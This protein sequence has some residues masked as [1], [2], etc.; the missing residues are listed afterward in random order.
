MDISE[1][2]RS[3][4]IKVEP[5]WGRE[6]NMDRN[7][8]NEGYRRRSP[9]KQQLH[10]SSLL[11]KFIAR[12]THPQLYTHLPHAIIPRSTPSTPR[13][14]I[15]SS[16]PS[17]FTTSYHPRCIHLPKLLI[18]SFTPPCFQTQSIGSLPI[19]IPKA[20]WLAYHDAI[21]FFPN[22]LLELLIPN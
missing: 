14:L 13:L 18:P 10:S 2:Y 4:P 22:S 3:P 20:A 8:M 7:P 17:P 19:F 11:P 1:A 9:G 6:D 5:R 12:A 15:P 16:T 21:I